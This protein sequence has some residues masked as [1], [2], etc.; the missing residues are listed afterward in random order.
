MPDPII[1]QNRRDNGIWVVIAAYNEAAAVGDVVQ[2][3]RSLFP[4]VIVVDDCSHDDTAAVAAGAGAMVLRH[5]I[6]LGQGAALQTGIV[7]AVVCGAEVVVTFDA[8][9]QH[10]PVDA[11][12]A[13]RAVREGKGDLVCGSRFL[14]LKAI[15]MPASRR[16]GLRVVT[17]VT[18]LLTG[19]P[20][21]DAHNG[22]R[23]LSRNAAL[24]IKITQN[25]MAHASEII[26]Q[27][28][29]RG[30]RYAEVPVEV[31]YTHY[32][33]GKGQRLLGGFRI[34]YDLILG[35]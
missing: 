35:G 24:S 17:G 8:D 30:L 33:R 12:T 32:S 13:A 31:R 22:L 7:R 14:G 18:R 10:R 11:Q 3:V 5:C 6:N 25:R 27:A 2:E 15:A 34:I 26:A 21:T 4:N 9:G 23:A 19:L 1:E 20:V 16:L 28:R 29:R